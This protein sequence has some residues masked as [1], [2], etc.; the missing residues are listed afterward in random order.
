MM[1]IGQLLKMTNGCELTKD[2]IQTIFESSLELNEAKKLRQNDVSRKLEPS[3]FRAAA[4]S[5][6]TPNVEARNPIDR[7]YT[8]N[9]SKT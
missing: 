5:M 1:L 9:H 8:E 3:V 7:L 6:V 2:R 4:L